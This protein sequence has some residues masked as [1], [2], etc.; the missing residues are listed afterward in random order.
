MWFVHLQQCCFLHI[1][2]SYSLLYEHLVGSDGD[3]LKLLLAIFRMMKPILRKEQIL[4][5]Y[6]NLGFLCVLQIRIAAVKTVVLSSLQAH[7]WMFT[8]SMFVLDP[9]CPSHDTA[10]PHRC[11]IAIK[12]KDAMRYG[13][14]FIVREAVTCILCQTSMLYLY[15]EHK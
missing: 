11:S 9:W 10:S 3:E 8:W 1:P 2:H 13:I 7:D 6:V 15:S 5:I 14:F 4:L 12:C